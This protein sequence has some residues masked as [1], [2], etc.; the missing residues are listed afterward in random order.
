M[1]NIQT[2]RRDPGTVQRS[3]HPVPPQVFLHDVQ[4]FGSRLRDYCRSQGYSA[5]QHQQ[6]QFENAVQQHQRVVYDQVEIAAVFAVIHAAAQMVSRFGHLENHVETNF[7]N[8]Q[9]GLLS[10]ITSVSAQALEAQRHSGSRG[11][12][13]GDVERNSQGRC[14]LSIKK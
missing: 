12:S 14:T 5:L 9:R 6:E 7:S 13:R 8:Q 4:N 3:A 1:L 11:H 10:E 2:A